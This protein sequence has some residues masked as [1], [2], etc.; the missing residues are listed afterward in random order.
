MNGGHPKSVICGHVPPFLTPDEASLFQFL[1][2][3][4]YT[5]RIFTLMIKVTTANTVACDLKP[6]RRTHHAKQDAF[7]RY[8]LLRDESGI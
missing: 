7:R 1:E 5:P 4:L 3:P 2:H 6:F 8:L